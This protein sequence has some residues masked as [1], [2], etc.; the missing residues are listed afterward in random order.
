[1]KRSVPLLAIVAGGLVALDQWSKH[2]ASANLAY[3]EP[4][5][6]VG[7]LVRLTYA[8]NSGIAFSLL[9]GRGFPLYV[10]SFIAALA[11]LVVFLRHE[12]LSL[13]RQLS[14][15]MILGGAV[16]NLIDRVSTGQVVDFIL[17]AWRGHEFPVF[18]V[19]DMA[20]S[21]GV[22]L[23]A[24]SWTR[25][26]MPEPDANE[27]VPDAAGTIDPPMD[28]LEAAPAS[29]GDG[30]DTHEDAGPDRTAAGGGPAGGSLARE[31]ADRPLP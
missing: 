13:P 1:V 21:I 14:L 6:V 8:R 29:P 27:H 25:D 17:L 28:P 9:A 12:R 11:V 4:V 26:E 3:R 10:F 2:W 20:V 16:G 24:L 22:T 23:F 19:A 30:T 15:A 18:N 5:H 7:D 31:G